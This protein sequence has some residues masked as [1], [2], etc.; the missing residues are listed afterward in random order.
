MF[1]LV[2]NYGS[3][4]DSDDD[5]AVA[6]PA[7]L[8]TASA[9][10]PAAGAGGLLHYGDDSD[11]D[12]HAGGMLFNIGNDSNGAID[13]ISSP[14]GVGGTRVRAPRT[15]KPLAEAKWSRERKMRLLPPEPSGPVD[16]A[17]NAKIQGM[18]ARSVQYSLQLLHQKS[19]HNPHAAE[20]IAVKFNIDQQ[21]SNYPTESYDCRRWQVDH[22]DYERI[23]REHRRKEASLPVGVKAAPGPIPGPRPSPPAASAAAP[24]APALRKNK[25]KWDQGDG[26]P[27]PKRQQSAS[28]AVRMAEQQ[29]KVRQI[30]ASLT[31][32][33][34]ANNAK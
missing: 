11:S 33:V 2:G 29:R 9:E 34:L 12:E 6:R 20:S 4:S 1:G 31:S 5:A 24:G 10:K 16:A 30:A 27:A 28:D 8:H 23:A 26:A 21:A 17:L 18:L 25:S 32:A 14:T 19:F 3:D 22:L 13:I 15:P 7:K